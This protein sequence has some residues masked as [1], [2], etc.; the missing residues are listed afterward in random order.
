M[1]EHIRTLP[2]TSDLHRVAFDLPSG[3]RLRRRLHLQPR[4]GSVVVARDVAAE[5]QVVYDDGYVA[6]GDLE[7][8]N[9]QDRLQIAR[10]LILGISECEEYTYVSKARLA[11]AG[12]G[13]LAFRC[14]QS[15]A[16][17]GGAS[18]GVR[19]RHSVPSQRYVVL[20]DRESA[21]ATLSCIGPLAPAAQ[22][23]IG[24]A[25]GRRRGPMAGM[26]S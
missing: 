7:I 8:R 15:D 3:C 26:F 5:A 4:D 9:D 17:T 20:Q 16:G 22:F 21:A 24:T 13:G 10:S 19:Q 12:A 2:H 1:L 6:L 18:H 23:R 14:R 11:S 25:L